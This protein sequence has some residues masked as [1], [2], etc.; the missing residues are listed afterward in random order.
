M[1]STS[2]SGRVLREPTIESTA[3][4]K[5]TRFRFQNEEQKTFMIRMCC[6]YG[7][8]YRQ[9]TKEK[10]WKLVRA[11]CMQ[12]FNSKLGHPRQ[13]VNTL[14]EQFE[15][16]IKYEDGVS[17]KPLL[18]TDFKQQCWKWKTDWLDREQN[19]GTTVKTEKEEEE[20]RAVEQRQTMMS[21]LSDKPKYQAAKAAVDAYKANHDSKEDDWLSISSDA[22]ISDAEEPTAADTLKR[23]KKESK[24]QAKRQKTAEAKEKNR[25]IRDREHHMEESMAN[26]QQAVLKCVNTMTN[27]FEKIFAPSSSMSI[28]V[29]SIAQETEQRLET[30]EKRVEKMEKGVEETSAVTKK[31]LEVVQGWKKESNSQ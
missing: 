6:L 23:P 15:E 13:M 9:G 20:R 12:E 28:T 21:T 11:A 26:S 25:Y 31:I 10:F 18:D 7:D 19:A 8:L 2:T 17:G 5:A 24:R 29:P 30:L 4:Q 27:V 22:T 16:S 1:S 3:T 14:M